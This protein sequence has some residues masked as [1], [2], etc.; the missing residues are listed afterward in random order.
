MPSDYWRTRPDGGDWDRVRYTTRSPG[1]DGLHRLAR[2]LVLSHGTVRVLLWRGSRL[3]LAEAVDTY[4]GALD[5]AREPR[6]SYAL[7]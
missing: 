7:A 5:L 4:E 2:L 3:V 1:D 6:A